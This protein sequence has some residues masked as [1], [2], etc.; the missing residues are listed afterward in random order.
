MLKVEVAGEVEHTAADG[1]GP[2]SALDKA[3][4]KALLT[5][6]PEISKIHLVDYKVRVLGEGDGTSAKVR[7]LIES[8]DGES[9]WSTVGVSENIIQASLQALSD[10]INYQLYK[11]HQGE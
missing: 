1:H 10:S 6:Y 4:R 9:T 5:F 7:V 11:T 3:M 8:S 2:V